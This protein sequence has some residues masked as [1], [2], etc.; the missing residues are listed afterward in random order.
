MSTTTNPALPTASARRSRPLLWIGCA[1]LAALALMVACAAGGVFLYLSR[2]ASDSSVLFA[3]DFSDPSTGW[4]QYDEPG[5]WSRYEEGGLHITVRLPELYV[6]SS[7]GRSFQDFTVEVDGRLVEGPPDGIYGIIFRL[8]DKDNF[9]E[10]DV[11]ADGFY[12]LVRYVDGQWQP[13]V[14][15]TE[16]QVIQQGRSLNRLRVDAV[17]STIRLYVNGQLLASVTDATFRRGD[18]ALVAGTGEAAGTH[19]AFDNLRVTEPRPAP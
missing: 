15:W 6:W 1:T 10:F 18:I 17:G 16:T 12:V 19:I 13:I 11:S 14:D 8:Q 5:G 7:A 3:D 9:Y 2:P 4:S